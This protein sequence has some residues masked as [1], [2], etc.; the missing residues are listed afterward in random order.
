MG[1]P[2]DNWQTEEADIKAGN[3]QIDKFLLALQYAERKINYKIDLRV[4]QICQLQYKIAI[5]GMILLVHFALN[6]K[7]LILFFNV[8]VILFILS[9][10]THTYIYIYVLCNLI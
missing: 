10:Y 4:N 6:E 3:G 9:L 1:G 7:R 8:D 5:R 2:T